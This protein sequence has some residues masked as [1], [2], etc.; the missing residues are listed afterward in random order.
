MSWAMKEGA[1]AGGGGGMQLEELVCSSENAVFVVSAHLLAHD[2]QLGVH[3]D[4]EANMTRSPQGEDT[5]TI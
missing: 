5:H 3:L 1:P 4:A 2:H